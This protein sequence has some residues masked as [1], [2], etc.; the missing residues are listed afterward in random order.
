MS[1]AL[2]S[3]EI[4]SIRSRL[5]SLRILYIEI[6]DELLD[7]YIAALE[8]VS[9]EEFENKK[10]EL[11]DEFSYATLR[12]M[13]KELYKNMSVRVRTEQ[14]NALK[15]WKIDR[16][17]ITGILTYVLLLLGAYEWLSLE[18]MM[19][20]CYL[21]PLVLFLVV[22]FHSRKSLSFNLKANDHKPA[23]IILRITVIQYLAFITVLN[24]L[25]Q[26]LTAFFKSHGM[27]SWALFAGIIYAALFNMWGLSL[28]NSF[29]LKT[30]KLITR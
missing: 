13:E 11:D 8:Q 4:A 30:L 21:A 29:N 15:F 18:A 6:Y 7:H 3:Q 1:R 16:K 20:L 10:Q 26:I 27:S 24:G 2:T 28:I 23:K 9:S 14:F 5:D 12:K 17:K 22:I 25:F 19:T